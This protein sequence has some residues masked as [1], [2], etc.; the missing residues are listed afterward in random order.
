MGEQTK[1][2]ERIFFLFIFFIFKSMNYQT[3][4]IVFIIVY[5]NMARRRRFASGR[6]RSRANHGFIHIR[7]YC[8]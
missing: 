2:D 3:E 8:M 1:K 4:Q 7:M 6:W 5:V